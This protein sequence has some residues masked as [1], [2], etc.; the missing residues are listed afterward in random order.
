[1]DNTPPDFAALALVRA[2]CAAWDRL[3]LDAAL[4]MLA[5]DIHYHNIPMP[6]LDGIAAVE[7]YLRRAAAFDSAAWEIV[8]IAANGSTVLTERV[9]R[10]LMN[11]QPIA[12]PVMGAFEV[13]GGK[14][15]A[16]RDY[17]DLADYQRQLAAAAAAGKAA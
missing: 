12:L 7:A 6:A 17:F 3:D 4:A 10:F 13:R 11:G 14:I 2:F 5:D 9:D 8:A 16:W 1:M 15:A